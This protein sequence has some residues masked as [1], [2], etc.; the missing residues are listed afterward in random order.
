ME[1]DE[2][3]L[4][5]FAEAA[6]MS[7]VYDMYRYCVKCYINE[8]NK[9]LPFVSVDDDLPCKHEEL[10]YKDES[11]GYTTDT[12]LVITSDNVLSYSFMR[13]DKTN[14]KWR[15]ACKENNI[16]QWLIVPEGIE[17][18]LYGTDK[19]RQKEHTGADT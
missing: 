8:N 3:E 4:R 11:R 16:K 1:K 9:S 10:I 7:I 13:L 14:G 6:F 15:W 19:A 2:K 12:V 5:E 17:E 18:F